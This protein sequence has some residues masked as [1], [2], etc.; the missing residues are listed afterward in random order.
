MDHTP[1]IYGLAAVVCAALLAYVATPLIRVLAYQLGAVDVPR[2][3]RRMHR[4][5]IPRMGGVAISLAFTVTTL[6][7]GGKK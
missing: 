3:N 4:V 7:F 6:A 2:D 1:L 5:P